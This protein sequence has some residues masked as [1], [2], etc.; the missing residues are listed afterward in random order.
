MDERFGDDEQDPDL[1]QGKEVGDELP[2]DEDLVYRGRADH[3]QHLLTLEAMQRIGVNAAELWLYYLSMGGGVDEY[4]VDA[5]LHGLIRLPAVDRDMI[6]QSVNEMIDDICRGPR[7]PYSARRNSQLFMSPPD[8]V[9]HAEDSHRDAYLEAVQAGV[10]ETS[11]IAARTEPVLSVVYSS[12]A[13]QSF[14]E[15]DLGQLLTRS[16]STNHASHLT[17]LLLYR[18]G[19]FLQVLEGPEAT[20]RDRLA[21]I[22]ADPRHTRIRTLSKKDGMIASSRT[23]PWVMNPSQPPCPTRC[24]GTS[25]RSLERRTTPTPP[26]P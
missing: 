3:D 26:A 4:E 10:T 2:E 11:G 14:K 15:A 18:R 5:Y 24:R 23:G 21:I 20:V 22:R 12:A 9:T 16:R 7:A 8:A 19:R 6:S 17:G 1:W 13:T 25:G